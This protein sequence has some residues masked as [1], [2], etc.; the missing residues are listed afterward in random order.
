[1]RRVVLRLAGLAALLVSGAADAEERI[2]SY[3][4]DVAVREDSSLDVTETITVRAENVA[5]NHGIYRDFPTRYRDRLGQK[6]RV[7]F[8]VQSV[9]RDGAPEKYAL[10]SVGNGVRIRIGD[11]NVN[12]PYGE[13]SYTI[14][15]RTT[16]QLGFFEGFDEAELFLSG[17]PLRTLLDELAA[18][19]VI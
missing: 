18:A 15:Y 7:D 8:D 2:L 16:R 1:M 12:L 10:E 9:E 4:S 6:V 5:I 11:A 13:H 14:R 17:K 19:G 3:V